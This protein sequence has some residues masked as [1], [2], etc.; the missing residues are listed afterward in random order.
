MPLCPEKTSSPPRVILWCVSN[1]GH[2]VGAQGHL[3]VAPACL[4]LVTVL[5]TSFPGLAG[6]LHL[7]GAASLWGLCPLSPG[8]PSWYVADFT[9]MSPSR[10]SEKWLCL[11]GGCPAMWLTLLSHLHPG[12]L[13]SSFVQRHLHQRLSP[14]SLLR[15]VWDLLISLVG[16]ES[17]PSLGTLRTFSEDLLPCNLSSCHFR[18]VRR[19]GS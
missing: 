5:G 12:V 8:W 2:P 19:F 4:S 17:P 11:L 14:S 10:A 9:V 1:S 15:Q 18:G 3:T 16:T 6:Q 13:S 7:I